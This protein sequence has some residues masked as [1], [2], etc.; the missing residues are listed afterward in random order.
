MS[1]HRFRPAVLLAV[2]ASLGHA[3]LAAAPLRCTPS[4]P[5]QVRLQISVTGV[6]STAGRVTITIYPDD[7]AHFLDGKFKLARQSL[8][9]GLPVTRACFAFAKP[10]YYAVALFHDRDDSGH[11]KTTALGIPAEGFGFSNNPTLYFGPP[12]LSRVRVKARFG[13]NPI[14]IRMKH[15]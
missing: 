5:H 9:V 1:C 15:Y 8:P 14:A 12:A 11:F 2:L 7:A 3:A 10:G 6:R 13:D 4:D